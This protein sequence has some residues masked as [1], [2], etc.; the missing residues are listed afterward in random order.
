MDNQTPEDREATRLFELRNVLAM[1][2][3]R[4][5]TRGHHQSH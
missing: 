5:L 1:Q 2:C 3:G 4:I